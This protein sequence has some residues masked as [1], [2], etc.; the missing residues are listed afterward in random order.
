[1]NDKSAA[2]MCRDIANEIQ[3]ELNYPGEVRVTLIRETRCV[4]Y[5]R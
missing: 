3:E 1:V 5:A 2:K 4:E